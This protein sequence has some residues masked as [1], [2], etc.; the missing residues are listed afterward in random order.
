VINFLEHVQITNEES[1][2]NISKPLDDLLSSLKYLPTQQFFTNL[3]MEIKINIL[4]YLCDAGSFIAASVCQEWRDMMVKERLNKIKKVSIGK[5]CSNKFSCENSACFMPD[6]MLKASST[7]KLNIPIEICS[8]VSNVDSKIVCEGLMSVSKF[9]ITDD[10]KCTE[11]NDSEHKPILSED[12]TRELFQSLESKSEMV[13]SVSLRGLDMTHLDQDRLINCLL[14]KTEELFLD[15][16]RV[17]KN[18]LDIEMLVLKLLQV[19]IT[20]KLSHLYL[21]YLQYS[22][23]LA[24]DL[25]NALCRVKNVSLGKS[26]PLK[27]AT[28]APFVAWK[29]QLST[30]QCL[31]IFKE[32]DWRALMSP[33][34]LEVLVTKMRVLE[35]GGRFTPEQIQMIKTLPGARSFTLDQM[36][37]ARS[38]PGLK[39]I[40]RAQSY[41]V[42]LKR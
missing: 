18:G 11:D 30:I 4:S 8:P 7:L 9:S 2:V 21:G 34:D 24:V 6:E 17:G 42:I 26:F 40:D 15:Q 3:P 29:D 32:V 5:H 19:P 31:R 1:L 27:T 22:E 13:K 12:Q 25:A 28:T 33:K 35:I 36:K 41:F 37:A 39:V 14:L 38:L 10:C 16:G 23:H 20:L